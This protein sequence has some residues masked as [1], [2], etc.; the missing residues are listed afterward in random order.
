MMRSTMTTVASTM[1]PKSRA[2]MLRRLRDPPVAY[3]HTMAKSKE[4]GMTMAA[5][6]AARTLRRKTSRTPTTMVKPSSRTRQTVRSVVLTRLVR[7]WMGTMRTPLGRRLALISSTAAWIARRTS[8][9][10]SHRRMRTIPSTPPTGLA[11]W[12][13]LKIPVWVIGATFTRPMS[14]T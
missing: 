11:S 6:S 14:R 2:P 12:F 8:L 4:S 13:R 10:F 5:S 9:G 3:M 1:M 7:S